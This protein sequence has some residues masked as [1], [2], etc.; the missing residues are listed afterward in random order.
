MEEDLKMK[1]KYVVKDQTTLELQETAQ[2]GDIIDLTE[3]IS[4]DTSIIEK[5]INAEIDAGKDRIYAQKIEAEKKVLN[6]ETEKNRVEL[7]AELEGK[8][9]N[10]EKELQKQQELNAEKLKHAEENKTQALVNLSKQLEANYSKEIAELK[11]KL[12]RADKERELAVEQESKKNSEELSKKQLEISRLEVEAKNFKEAAQMEKKIAVEEEIKKKNEELAKKNEEITKLNAEA[13]AFKKQAEAD[14]ELAVSKSLASQKELLASKEQEIIKLKG[15]LQV[16]E[17]QSKNELE[18][19]RKTFDTQLKLMQE[20]VEQYKDFK[21]SLSTKK[22]GDTLEEHCL[23]E[24]NKYRMTAFQNVYFAKDNDASSGSKGD[25]RYRENGEDGSEVLSIMFEMKNEME[26]T[27][28]KH[29]NETF[30]KELD[31]DRKEKKCE[32]AVLVSMLEKDNEFYN[33][34]IADVSYQYPKMYVIRPQFFIPLITILRNCAYNAYKYKVEMNQYKMANIDVTNFENKLNDFKTGFMGNYN[35][36]AKNFEEAIK[37]IDATIKKMEDIKKH[38]QTT[39]NQL[40]LENN[41]VDEVSI[42]KLTYNNPTMKKMFAEAKEEN[43]SS[44]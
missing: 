42:K 21:Q 24:F 32:Y 43:T 15:D 40:R 17:Q 16:Q 34:G 35:S 14:K 33:Q 4:I 31:K 9:K 41:K 10:L 13:T 29:K 2:K 37:D 36:A 11:G 38:L 22:L 18:S 27:E 30:F 8:I 6:A 12:E 19:Q 7:K 44:D 5:R 3:E 20:Q 28:S 23:N 39:Q 25:F 26:S 1:V